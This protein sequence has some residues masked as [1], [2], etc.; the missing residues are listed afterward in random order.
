M[1]LFFLLECFEGVILLIKRGFR[2]QDV[3]AIYQVFSRVFTT[4]LA[5]QVGYASSQ[6]VRVS[7]LFNGEK[8]MFRKPKKVHQRSCTMW[9]M[10]HVMAGTAKACGRACRTFLQ[11]LPWKCLWLKRLPQAQPFFGPDMRARQWRQWPNTA[12]F[13]GP[14][15]ASWRHPNNR[16]VLYNS[17]MWWVTKDQLLDVSEASAHHLICATTATPLNTIKYPRCPIY[18]IDTW[19][20]AYRGSRSIHGGPRKHTR[21]MPHWGVFGDAYKPTRDWVSSARCTSLEW[22][23][24]DDKWP[25]EISDGIVDG[26]GK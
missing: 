19:S 8:V 10:K 22:W 6:I 21:R 16:S 2:P 9:K 25:L 12:D 17:Y 4:M 1:R 11:L 7:F 24:I 13:F 5:S 20:R 3:G 23:G 15:L 18:M 26:S 14:G